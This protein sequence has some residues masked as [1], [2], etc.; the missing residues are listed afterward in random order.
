MDQQTSWKVSPE[1]EDTLIA[2]RLFQ[3]V[4]WNQS[5]EKPIDLMVFLTNLHKAW[6][7]ESACLKGNSTLNLRLIGEKPKYEEILKV[8]VDEIEST[9]NIIDDIDLDPTGFTILITKND[10]D[11]S[12]ISAT[13]DREGYVLIDLHIFDKKDILNIL[14]QLTRN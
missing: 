12:H 3:N 14:P 11:I 4:F 7:F 2:M 5:P 13:I 8:L 9:G 1:A 10:S 6:S